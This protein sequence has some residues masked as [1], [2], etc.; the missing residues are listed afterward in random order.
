[1]KILAPVNKPEE[2]EKLIEEGADELYC[3]VLPNSWRNKYTNVA[4]PNRR[5]WTTA[6]LSD[7]DELEKTVN[8]AHTYRIPV[9]LAINSFYS[10]KQ[11][12]LVLKQ[13]EQAKVIGVDAFIIA[14]LGLLLALK[15]KKLD[16]EIH[17]SNTGTSFNSESIKFYKDLGASRIILPRQLMLDE[18]A[19]LV[20]GENE[21]KFEVFILNS[22]CKNID[23]FCTFHHGVNE[24]LHPLVWNSFKRLDFDRHLLELIRKLPCS[25]LSRIK[26]NIFG[27]DSACL[28]NYKVSLISDEAPKREI[29]SVCKAVSAGFSLLSGADPCGVC[30]LYKLKKIGIHSVKIVGRNYLTS[31]KTKDVKFLKRALIY[32]EQNPY[33]SEEQFKAR[34]KAGYKDIYKMDCNHLCYRF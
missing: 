32:L 17:I 28:L 23:G 6:N 12:P 34:V 19:E 14:D 26:G 25:L 21:I 7:L 10:D 1:M 15:E 18:I 22:G 11:Y 20:E 27:I 5:E 9:Y 3:G 30:D 13:I 29:S 4:S 2:V 8:I 33:I 24:I 31:K 16:I